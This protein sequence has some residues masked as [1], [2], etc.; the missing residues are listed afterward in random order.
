[1]EK[2]KGKGLEGRGMEGKGGRAGKR[3]T[4]KS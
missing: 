2:N 1:M 3:R 4:V